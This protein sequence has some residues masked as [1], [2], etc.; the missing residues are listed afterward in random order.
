[1]T[2]IINPCGCFKG[3]VVRGTRN[4]LHQRPEMIKA[5]QLRA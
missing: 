1:M 4:G 5:F 3:D 2:R